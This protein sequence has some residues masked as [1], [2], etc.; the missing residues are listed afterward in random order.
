MTN[1]SSRQRGSK[2]LWLQAAYDM[3]ISEGIDAV[4]IMPLANKLNLTRT[5]FYWFFE[6]IAELHEA[7]IAL[8]ESKN[9]E[10]LITQCN[11]PASNIC[12][13]LFHIMDCWLDSDL[14]DAPL[15][16]AIRNWARKDA[17]LKQQL[18]SADAQRIQ[19]V[20]EMFS[21]FEFNPE[22][23]QV[24]GLTVMLTQIGYISMQINEAR[25]ERLARVQ[26]YV[27]LFAGMC[28][29]QNDVDQFLL[30]HSVRK[31]AG[32]V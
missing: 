4:K 19:A 21:R 16:L 11:K 29:E 15:D 27:E 30:R 9:T 13:A 5:G 25:N 1:T 12:Q 8:W 26:H 14:F 17:K 2:D 10:I 18:D 32:P 28:P 24:R 6:D 3:L 7:M 20:A 31:P 23:A 22:Q